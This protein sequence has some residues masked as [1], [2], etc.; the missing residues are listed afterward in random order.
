MDPDCSRRFCGGTGRPAAY[1]CGTGTAAAV[2]K[3]LDRD[4]FNCGACG[5]V[6]G[7]NRECNAVVQSGV[8]SGVCSCNNS[9]QCPS[10]QTCAS[11]SG[12]TGVG[13]HCTCSSNTTCGGAATCTAGQSGFTSPGFC[14]Y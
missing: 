13:S 2:C 1:C 11:L 14:R 3:D 7:T 6:C 5:T 4:F 9:G 8:T 10:N 12:V